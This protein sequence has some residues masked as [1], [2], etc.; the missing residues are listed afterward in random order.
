MAMYLLSNSVKHYHWGHPSLIPDFLGKANPDG[1]PVAEVWMGTHPGGP[2]QVETA[3]G[4]K[5]L[6]SIYPAGLPFLLKLLAARQALSIQAHPNLE[7]A[8]SGFFWENE[9]GLALTDPRRNYKDSNHK[10]EVLVALGAPF[11]G[12]AGFREAS[13]IRTDLEALNRLAAAPLPLLDELR[14][15]LDRGGLKPLTRSLLC[16]H[17]EAWQVQEPAMLE[18]FAHWP[19]PIAR[20]YPKLAKDFPGDPSV[21]F[22]VI[23]NLFC[24]EPGA[25][26]F[27]P[28]GCF[29]AYLEGFGLELM[30]ASDNVLRGGLT[31]K[32]V[33]REELE[34]IAV[35]ESSRPQILTPVTGANG[36]GVFTPPVSDFK[37]GRLQTQG[38]PQ[39]LG[40]ARSPWIL[41][42]TE[43][44]V[45][46]TQG[47]ETLDLK[48]GESAV[49]LPTT[50]EVT[51]VGEG[52]VYR[53]WS[54]E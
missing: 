52:T 2:S 29:H 53:A 49:L 19:S 44:G 10:P 4:L 40:I 28:A 39:H 31:P 14:A 38:S 16:A 37:L 13:E 54:G 15:A 8:Q 3:E 50:E 18:A 12:L 51:L 30:A 7:Q 5:D 11:W 46:I 36:E 32:P 41:I 25:A 27:I 24:L 26:L 43:G 6:R 35:F 22:L 34:R 9:R 48:K 45:R 23:L 33:D 1:G 21:L 17:R 47:P 42:V 20:W